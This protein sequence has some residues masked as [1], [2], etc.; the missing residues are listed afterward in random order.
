MTNLDSLYW[1][2]KGSG[3]SLGIDFKSIDTQGRT[4]IGFASLDNIDF[5]SDIVPLEA[6][7]KAFEDFRGNIRMQ[8]DKTRPVGTLQGFEVADY[9]DHKTGK[10]H[11]GIKVAVRI[12]KG[13]EDVWEMVQDGTLS[14][15]SIGAAIESASKIYD[16]ELRKNVRVIDSYKLMELSLVDSP[17]NELC[18]VVSVHKSIDEYAGVIEKD[19]VNNSLVWCGLDRIAKKGDG[20]DHCPKCGEV[21]VVLG[22]YQENVD[23][24]T[25][26]NKVF[27]I[28]KKG[29]HPEVADTV[30]KDNNEEVVSEVEE[31]SAVEAV[32]TSEAEA[33]VE[34]APVVEESAEVEAEA[35]AEVEAET[36]V[37]V[38]AE[39]DTESEAVAEDANEEA[40]AEVDTDED[41]SNAE[42]AT[43]GFDESKFQEFLEQLTEI[44]ARQAEESR[45]S[46][47]SQ[48]ET[49]VKSVETLVN[50]VKGL[51]E[52]QDATENSVAEVREKMNDTNDRLDVVAG[53][54]N[55]HLTE[56]A[57]K[58]SLDSSHDE[59]PVKKSREA[60][61]FDGFFSQGIVGW[62]S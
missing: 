62:D 43:P 34:E 52:S 51:K 13:A 49:V 19:F 1:R 28:S 15:F 60:D 57:V 5:A 2:R 32:E 45:K 48:L 6:S 25:Q 46:A 8:H 58:K 47:D 27:E 35:D 37:E 55:K 4:V 16:E 20:S 50:I 59:S 61:L 42:A 56:P 17:M 40:V 29:G 31:T 10:T 39:A 24:G 3:L 26:I 14:A 18:N 23:I 33:P 21:M 7:I 41:T 54:V 36:D 30:E 12:S 9:Y 44:F 38:E 22:N 11:K 53:D